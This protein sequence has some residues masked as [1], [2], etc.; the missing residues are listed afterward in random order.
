MCHSLWN[1]IA[2]YMTT[3]WLII[4]K[5]GKLFYKAT[6]SFCSWQPTFS[7]STLVFT[8]VTF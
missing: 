1:V 4:K 2:K 5:P 3:I 8:V 6:A 7:V